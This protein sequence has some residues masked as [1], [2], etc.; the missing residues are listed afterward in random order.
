MIVD[1]NSQGKVHEP[2]WYHTKG[3]PI[4]NSHI[5]TLYAKSVSHVQNAYSLYMDEVF[6]TAF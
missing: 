2:E 5:V 3:K 4:H 6:E 1:I